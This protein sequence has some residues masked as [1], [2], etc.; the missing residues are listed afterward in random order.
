MAA[1]F[2]LL[3]VFFHVF[4]TVYDYVPVIGPLFRD[5]FW[6]VYLLAGLGMAT[7]SCC[8]YARDHFH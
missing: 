3:M 8:C 5:R 4:T 1:L 6:F 2:L 7:V